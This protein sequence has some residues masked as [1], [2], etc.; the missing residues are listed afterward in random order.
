MR[1]K[2]LFVFLLLIC[3]GMTFSQQRNN[4]PDEYIETENGLVIRPKFVGG[5]ANFYHFVGTIYE[6]PKVKRLHGKVIIQF[7]VETDG[8]LA[9]I[10]VLKDIGYGTGNEAIRVMK[11]SP[12][13]IPGTLNGKPVRV[14]YTLPISVDTR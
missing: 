10:K 1:I 13:W 9:D 2:V 8:S 11:A 7:V 14:L 5:I 12:K 4:G 6:L 3:A